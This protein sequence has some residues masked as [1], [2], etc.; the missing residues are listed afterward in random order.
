M[1]GEEGSSAHAG[2]S[3]E[4]QRGG[5]TQARWPSC[6]WGELSCPSPPLLLPAWTSAVPAPAPEAAATALALPPLFGPS[7]CFLG[8]AFGWTLPQELGRVQGLFWPLSSLS[9]S[10]VPLGPHRCARC[11]VVSV[12]QMS[13]CPLTSGLCCPWLSCPVLLASPQPHRA[14]SPR[15]SRHLTK[16][17]T[18]GCVL[19]APFVI[20]VL[21]L[22]EGRARLS[23]LCCSVWCRV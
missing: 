3:D 5:G 11:H 23:D 9:P 14:T 8:S 22:C 10:T 17:Q 18:L 16:L 4:A 7:P 20:H 15:P 2:Q 19:I 13:T 21:A 1:N 6:S 12:P